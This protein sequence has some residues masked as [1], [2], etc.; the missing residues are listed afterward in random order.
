M[1]KLHPQRHLENYE[2]ALKYICRQVQY[3]IFLLNANIELTKMKTNTEKSLFSKLIRFPLILIEVIY[4][5][6]PGNLFK[7]STYVL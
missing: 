7:D 6:K 1:R 3:L 2:N 5:H 4:K